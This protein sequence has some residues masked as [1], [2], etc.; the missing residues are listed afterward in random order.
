MVDC[1]IFEVAPNVMVNFD[2]LF[3]WP[4]SSIAY[5]IVFCLETEKFF[6]ASKIVFVLYGSSQRSVDRKADYI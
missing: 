1:S 5:N 2:L 4:L 6:K 3:Q